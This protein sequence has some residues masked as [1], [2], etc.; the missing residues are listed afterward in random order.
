MITNIDD[1]LQKLLKVIDEQGVA[2]NT[3]FIFMTDNGSAAGSTPANARREARGFTA[4]MRAKKGS[5]YDGGHRVPCFIRYPKA[6]PVDSEFSKLTAHMDLLPTLAEL[7]GLKDL[8]TL[9]AAIFYRISK[10]PTHGPRE[11][12]SC[13]RIAWKSQ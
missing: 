4:G 11:L 13:S 9:T 5:Q 7:C 6:L 12:K 1:N 8:P 10:I 3:I 2:D